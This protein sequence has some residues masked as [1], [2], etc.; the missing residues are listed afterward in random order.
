MHR[1][2]SAGF[3]LDVDPT[4]VGLDDPPA[5]G[6]AEARAALFAGASFVHAVETLEDVGQ[7]LRWDADAC[8]GHRHD[9]S[10]L[11]FAS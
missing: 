7:I 11:D 1:C 3:A 4:P 9:G 8:V 10:I 6:Q 5:N 2:T